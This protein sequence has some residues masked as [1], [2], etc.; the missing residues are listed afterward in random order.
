MKIPA[1]YTEESVAEVII[2]IIKRFA[3]KFAFPPHSTED[4]EQEGWLFAI[5][6]LKNYDG[7]R[8]LYKFLHVHIRNRYTNFLRDNFYRAE[9]PCIKC[10]LYDKIKDQCLG[11]AE[12]EDCDKWRKYVQ[13]NESRRQLVSMETIPEPNNVVQNDSDEVVERAEVDEMFDII[14]RELP[15]NLRSDYRRLMD[16]SPLTKKRREKLKDTI[17]EILKRHGYAEG[18]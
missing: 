10:P 8:P 13:R 18:K 1:G 2:P 6:G 12:R 15:A 17:R 5:E 16:N 7:E 14:D 9:P 11:F 3:R 4:M